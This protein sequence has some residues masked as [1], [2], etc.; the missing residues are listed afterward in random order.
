METTRRDFVRDSLGTAAL[1]GFVGER[2]T[3]PQ[4]RLVPARDSYYLELVHENDALLPV[5][6]HGI[7]D[8]KRRIE[9]R[10]LAGALGIVSAAYCAPESVHYKSGELLAVLAQAADRLLGLQHPDGT[11]DQGNYNSPPDTGFV[12]Q[13]VCTSL[14]VLRLMHSAELGRVNGQLETFVRAAGDALSVGGIHTPNHRWV[15]SSALAQVNALFPSPKYVERIDD[16]LSEGIDCDVDGQYSERSTGIYSRVIDDALITIARK[17]HRPELLNPVRRNLAMNLFYMHPDGEL[18]TVA[19]RRQDELA[20]GWITTYYLQYRY[21]AIYDNNRQFAAATRFIEQRG[22]DHA[23][24]RVP[25]IEFLEEPLYGHDLPAPEPLPSNYVRLFGNSSL[26]RIRKEEMSATVYGGSDWP[27]GFA[28]GLASNPTFF[29]LRKG[30]AVLESV[31]MLPDFFS[32][33]FFRSKGMKVEGNRYFLQQQVSVPYYQPLPKRLRNEKGDY[34]L[35]SAGG[36]FWSKLN[37]PQRPT[38]NIQ[39]LN[40]KITVTRNDCSFEL[41]FD[42]DGHDGVPITV[43]LTFRKGGKF[44]GAEPDAQTLDVY[45]LRQGTGQYRVG[46]DTITFGPGQVVQESILTAKPYDD[47]YVGAPHSDS[48]RLYITGLTPFRRTLSIS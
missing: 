8:T 11:I 12:V 39:S 35:T 36:R 16:W 3:W 13:G 44:V 10:S 43:E 9:P 18:E 47:P 33:G 27:L 5:T 23:E 28:S 21:M 31:R 29:N 22:L 14:T 19:S 26:A 45:R 40:Q 34:P 46:E 20:R 2:L 15:V 42:V 48:Y 30:A 17:L 32:E 24:P 25:L 7:G 41:A 38:S 6:V 4:E 37:F 1:V